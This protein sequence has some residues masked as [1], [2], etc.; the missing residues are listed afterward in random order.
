ME[1]TRF[2]AFCEELSGFLG[3]LHNIEATQAHPQ[4]NIQMSEDSD[5]ISDPHASESEVEDLL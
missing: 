3:D 5:D 2:E 1:P 4:R